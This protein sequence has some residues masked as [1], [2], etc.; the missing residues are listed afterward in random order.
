MECNIT[1]VRTYVCIY[2]YIYIYTTV[3][4][5]KNH[6]RIEHLELQ[7]NESNPYPWVSTA[8]FFICQTRQPH[9][10]LA[11]SA[12]LGCWQNAD[13]WPT[14]TGRFTSANQGFTQKNVVWSYCLEICQ[15]A[16]PTRHMVSASQRDWSGLLCMLVVC[17]PMTT[18]G[19]SGWVIGQHRSDL[20]RSQLP[21]SEEWLRLLDSDDTRVI[22]RG[23]PKSSKS[24]DQFRI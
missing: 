14:T 6:P 10:V 13:F 2:T 15:S 7:T 11:P 22:W 17:L 18:S 19:W 23:Y 4:F 5:G 16:Y 9:G 8:E 12:K 3:D 20:K 1:Y 24:L 21:E